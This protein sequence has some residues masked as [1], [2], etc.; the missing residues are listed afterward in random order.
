MIIYKITN[1]IN[2]KVYI[3]QT[4]RSLTKRWSEHVKDANRF[5]HHFANAIRKYGKTSFIKEV[6][7]EV[8][9]VDLL[10]EREVHWI[11]F[12]NSSNKD[13]GYNCTEGGA[14]GIRGYKH[15][16]TYKDLMSEIMTGENNGMYGKSSWNKGISWDEQHRSAQSM[17][18]KGRYKG[19]KHHLFGV[20]LTEETKKKKSIA[21]KGKPWSE[22]RRAAQKKKG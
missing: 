5:D 16:E 6:L 21:L 12:F 22:A 4:T 1:L 3:G 18:M 10:D 11:S 13:I 17:K 2:G 9:S 14:Y 19:E 15:T 8:A 20:S 7:E